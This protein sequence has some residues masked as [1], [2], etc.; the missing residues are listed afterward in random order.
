MFN[1]RHSVV[2][3]VVLSRIMVVSMFSFDVDASS[4]HVV[5]LMAHVV[6]ECVVCGDVGQLNSIRRKM[7]VDVVL[8]II[9]TLKLLHL[10]HKNNVK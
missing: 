2:R 7:K 6:R 10:K 8:F 9:I 4:I 3:F 5:S 1:M